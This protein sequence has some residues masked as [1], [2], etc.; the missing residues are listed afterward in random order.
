MHSSGIRSNLST[1]VESSP[2]ARRAANVLAT[3]LDHPAV[4][5]LASLAPGSRR[6]V[7]DGLRRTARFFGSTVATLEC[8]KITFGAV[9]SL[10]S[11]LAEKHSPAT[12]N[13]V[14]SALR[15]VLKFCVRLGKM[16]RGD[17]LNAVDVPTVK[18][19]REPAGRSLS[20]AEI[21]KMF[22]VC[23]E[24][25]DGGARDRCLLA[26]LYGG[27][28]RRAELSALNLADVE[29]GIAIRVRGKGNKERSVQLAPPVAEALRLWLEV[30]GRAPGPLVCSLV[31]RK[32]TTNRL[33]PPGIYCALQ[34]LADR[35]D[36]EH[37][38]PHD[39]RRSLIGDMLDLGVDLPT[40][41]KL[42]GHS[43]VSTT[44]RYDRRGIRA[45][46]EAVNRLEFQL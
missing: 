29:G 43:D 42:V 14:L 23:R 20:S 17:M 27:G 12:A 10:R 40:V 9:T 44:A 8:H 45:Q 11:Y 18:G 7:V 1:P 21:A 25:G 32:L 37:F 16:D 39:L 30:R 24:R 6:S 41:Q 22:A 15:G 36:V 13:R 26:L 28:L 5:Y 3:A 31:Y 46:R 19:S 34:L 4:L 2:A 38:S 35:A 33:T